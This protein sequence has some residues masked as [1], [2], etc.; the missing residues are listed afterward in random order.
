MFVFTATFVVAE[1]HGAG[2]CAESTQNHQ[3]HI[4]SGS[5]AGLI[6][7]SVKDAPTGSTKTKKSESG[8]CH[9]PQSANCSVL[10]TEETTL[11]AVFPILFNFD[12]SL[13]NEQLI[14][15]SLGLGL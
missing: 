9:C 15:R 1:S 7:T 5:D 12:S 10:A 13:A 8:Q 11:K 14:R 2:L 6:A 4:Q 3:S